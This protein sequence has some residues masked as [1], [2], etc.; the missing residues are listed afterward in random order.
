MGIERKDRTSKIGEKEEERPRGRLLPRV[1]RRERT[2][3]AS[4]AGDVFG[5][6]A[7][8]FIEGV[9]LAESTIFSSSRATI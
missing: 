2:S 8:R 1:S 9:S 7:A 5:H 4:F 3:M 6:A